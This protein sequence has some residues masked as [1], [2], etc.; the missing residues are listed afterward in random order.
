MRRKLVKLAL[1]LS[2]LAVAMGMAQKPVEAAVS[3]CPAYQCC[4]SYCLLIRPC[5][6]VGG[7]CLCSTLCRPG[8]GGGSD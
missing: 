2:L 6:F 5:W 3:W 4:D 8:P 1:G 7:S